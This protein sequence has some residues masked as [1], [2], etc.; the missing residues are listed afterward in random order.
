MCGDS[1]GKSLIYRKGAGNCKPTVTLERLSNP[2]KYFV[3]VP[4]GEEAPADLEINTSTSYD[5]FARLHT[6]GGEELMVVNWNHYV[7]PRVAR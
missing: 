5:E 1:R 3:T 4:N 7:T 2:G 6:L